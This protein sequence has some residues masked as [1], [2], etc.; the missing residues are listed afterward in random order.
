MNIKRRYAND[1]TYRAYHE[2]LNRLASQSELLSGS[3]GRPS[4]H[5]TLADRENIVGMIAEREG[6]TDRVY[7]RNG[8]KMP[9]IIP[10]IEEK[11]HWIDEQYE[12]YKRS[13]RREG[14]EIP[15]FM[16]QEMFLRKIRHEAE[17][18]VTIAEIKVL[19]QRLSEFSDAEELQSQE[20]VLKNGLMQHGKMQNG[21]LSTIDGQTVSQLHD[22]TL[23]INDKRS[24]YNLLKVVDFRRLAAEWM[25]ARQEAADRAYVR[26]VQAAKDSGLPLPPKPI[27]SHSKTFSINQ[28]PDFPEWAERVNVGEPK[29]EPKM[30]RIR[31][32]IES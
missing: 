30:F 25:S 29:S 5:S 17:L 11:I 20:Q 1:D 19:K 7:Y 13:C 24:P 16:P 2:S 23:Y 28:L 26:S 21:T 4:V 8:E 10:S 32:P 9:A 22:G 12:D 14:K 15:D 18:D 27:V 6:N 31:K 3:G